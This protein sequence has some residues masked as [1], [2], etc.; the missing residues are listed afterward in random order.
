MDDLTFNK[1]VKQLNKKYFQTFGEIPCMQN[2]DCSRE[3]YIL[4]LKQSINENIKIDNILAKTG[5][6]LD[7]NAVV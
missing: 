6:P 4:A 1:N 2:F 5:N 7:K 3:E